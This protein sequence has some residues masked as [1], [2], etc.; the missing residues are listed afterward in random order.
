MCRPEKEKKVWSARGKEG[1]EERRGRT[2]HPSS[3]LP[4]IS[5]VLESYEARASIIVVGV[6]LDPRGARRSSK[7]KPI[8]EAVRTRPLFSARREEEERG[9]THFLILPNL[10][11]CILKSSSSVSHEMFCKKTK[12]SESARAFEAVEE[13]KGTHADE[14]IIEVDEISPNVGELRKV[15]VGGGS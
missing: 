7:I 14:E 9:P 2:V 11:N 4:R 13:R 3:R 6:S 12:K 5:L 15:F 8:Q 1:E 10:E